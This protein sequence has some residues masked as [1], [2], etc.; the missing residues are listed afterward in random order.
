MLRALPATVRI[1][2]SR[3]AAFRSGIFVLAISSTCLL[4][5]LADLVGVRARAALL[6]PAAFL[7]STVAGGVLMMN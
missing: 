6:D 7:I 2:A 3:S 4:R 5:D 1:A